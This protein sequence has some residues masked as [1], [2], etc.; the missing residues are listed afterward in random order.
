VGGE[1]G[2]KGIDMGEKRVP[3][4]GVEGDGEAAKAVHG[5]ATLFGDLEANGT[6]SSSASLECVVLGFEG[7]DKGEEFF[8]SGSGGLGGKGD[9]HDVFPGMSGRDCPATIGR[10]QIAAKASSNV[11]VIEADFCGGMNA[12][13]RIGPSH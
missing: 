3:L 9:G 8:V 4:R 12:I 5:N 6:G 13:A 10:S 11:F 1:E 2:A 7:L